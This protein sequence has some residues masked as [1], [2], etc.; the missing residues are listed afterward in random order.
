MYDIAVR[1]IPV[2]AFPRPRRLGF[3]N[4]NVRFRFEWTRL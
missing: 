4:I 1:R 2:S 3:N